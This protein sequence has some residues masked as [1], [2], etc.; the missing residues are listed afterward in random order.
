MATGSSQSDNSRIILGLP[1]L[2]NENLT[3]IIYGELSTVYGAIFNLLRGISTYGGID[4]PQ[5]QDWA[6]SP[7]S[8]TFLVGNLTRLYVACGVAIGA[9]QLVNLYNNAGVLNAQLASASSAATLAHGVAN[10]AGAAGDIIEIQWMRGFITSIGGMSLGATYYLS[11]T[12]GAVQNLP[13]TAVGTIQQPIGLAIAASQ[14]LMDIP[15][16]YKQ[17]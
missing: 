9:G 12:A 10:I 6:Q 11:P 15:Y 3:P 16:F 13:P 1:Q 17:N 5:Q 4:A 7:P 8:A 2:P 14:L